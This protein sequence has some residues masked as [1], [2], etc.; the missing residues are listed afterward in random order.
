MT[1]AVCTLAFAAITAAQN[2]AWRA[3]IGRAESAEHMG[4]YSAAL[5][6][7]RSAAAVADGFGANDIRTWVS[8]NRLGMAYQNTG[9]PSEGIRCYRR[10]ITLIRHSVGTQNTEYAVAIANLATALVSIGDSLNGEILLREALQLETGALHA[11]PYDIAV[12]QTRLVEAL[13]ARGHYAEAERLLG[14]VLPVLRVSGD[15]FYLAVALNGLGMLRRHQH[16]YGE[17]LDAFQQTVE[18]TEEDRGKDHPIL[19]IPLNNL[20]ATYTLLGNVTEAGRVFRRAQAICDSSL[21]PGHPSHAALL[22]NYAEFLRRSG[23]KS[24]AKSVRQQA[25]AL[26]RDNT[27]RNG[28][29]LTVDVTAFRGN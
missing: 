23:E 7:Y 25:E 27:R 29:G 22:A 10:A 28:A 1:I 26:S 4:Y 3:D 20:A 8:Y 14:R 15:R 17:A 21:P 5:E 16:R 9:R 24:R 18:L 11:S 6:A 2:A 19:V 12:T 13:M